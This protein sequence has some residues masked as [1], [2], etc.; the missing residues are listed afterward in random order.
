MRI[1]STFEKRFLEEI[2]T[3]EKTDERLIHPSRILKNLLNIKS[4]VFI[5]GRGYKYE[6]KEGETYYYKIEIMGDAIDF[7]TDYFEVTGKFYETNDLMDYLLKNGYLL[8]HEGGK[9]L[10]FYINMKEDL[11]EKNTPGENVYITTSLKEF[12]DKCSYYYTP[13]EA[14]RDLVKHN[15]RTK[16]ERN[17]YWT[18]VISI[19]SICISLLGIGLNFYVNSHKAEQLKP[20]TIK[21]DTS[22][23]DYYIKKSRQTLDTSKQIRTDTSVKK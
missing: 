22:S 5:S 6:L 16:S 20:D 23:I 3:L 4:Q 15:F 17:N 7:P 9:V 18:R 21:L 2:V 12:L 14:L 11:V 8:R 19:F 10:G 13:T 1:L